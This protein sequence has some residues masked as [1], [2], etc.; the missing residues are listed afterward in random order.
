MQEVS[1]IKSIYH[2]YADYKAPNDDLQD[3]KDN[4]F[5]KM[6]PLQIKRRTLQV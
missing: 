5:R 1:D 4:C 2:T 3:F 6:A